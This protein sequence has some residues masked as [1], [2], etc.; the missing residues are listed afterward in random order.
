MTEQPQKACSGP[1]ES[2]S[3]AYPAGP[4]ATRRRK[5]PGV[6]IEIVTVGGSEGDHLEARQIEVIWEILTW[7]CERQ[8]P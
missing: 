4:G 6:Q 2:N 1:H 5:A 7:L 8:N 3:E